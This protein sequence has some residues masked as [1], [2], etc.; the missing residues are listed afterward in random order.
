MFG[1]GYN[2]KSKVRECTPELLDK[3]LDSSSVAKT[4]AELEDALE[5]CRR[6]ELTKEEY[7]T[8]KG[9]LKKLLPVATFQ[10]TF[11]H[12][13]RKNDEAIPSG[14]SIYDIAHI[15]NPRAKWEEIESRKEELGIVMAHITPST[16]GMRLV[17]VIPTAPGTNRLMSLAE[18]QAWMAS[19]LG[20]TTYDVCVKDYARC[21]FLVPRE[22][23]LFLSEGL[24]KT[25]GGILRN[26][27]TKNLETQS[28]CKQILRDA[29]DDKRGSGRLDNKTSYP[30]TYEGIPYRKIVETLEEQMGG[31]PEH[32]SRNNFIFSMACHLRYICDDDPDWIATILPTYG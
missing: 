1:I 23:V 10:A 31:R 30:E 29:Q 26:E 5:R 22:Y 14:L 2:I 16:E 3:V 19:M 25:T 21:S 6:G 27:E 13:R 20:D 17:F 15:P 11:K 24:F 12:G 7:E 28:G 4:C 32:G 18:A 9:E 8:M